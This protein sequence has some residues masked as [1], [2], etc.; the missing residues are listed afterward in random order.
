MREIKFRGWDKD[1]NRWYYGSYVR[2]E[3]TSPYAWSDS[4]EEATKKFEAEQVDHYIFFTEMNDW[5]LETKKLRA[6]VDPKS[7]GQYIGLTDKNG[8]EIYE[9]DVVMSNPKQSYDEPTIIEWSNSPSWDQDGNF[10]MW[11]G[12]W[13]SYALPEE[14]EVIGNI[15]ENPELIGAAR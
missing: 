4:P 15:Y 13:H 1:T 6:S 2:L 12:Y 9:G 3:R 11:S 5:G 8:T 7:V 14:V 10:A